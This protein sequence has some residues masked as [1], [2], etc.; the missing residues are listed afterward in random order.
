MKVCVRCNTPLKQGETFCSK[1]GGNQ[2][3]DVQPQQNQGH[4]QINKQPQQQAPNM[5]NQN[6]QMQGQYNPN[7]QGQYNPNMQ[8]Q[9][10]Y[11]QP[12]RGPAPVR[13]GMNQVQQPV[14]PAPKKKLFKSKAEKQAEM[15]AEMARMKQ[16]QAQR[17]QGQQYGQPQ[18]QYGQP[19]Q[20]Y[21]QP[22][23]QYGQPQ[24]QYGQQSNN[25]FSELPNTEMTVKDWIITLLYL[26]IPIWN[27]IYIVKNMN[28]P[29][30]G[31]YK[32]NF[33][34]A[35]GIYFLIS[36]GVRFP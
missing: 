23:Q 35:Y 12:N 7:M 5:Y 2:F 1:C 32:R 9:G 19:Q 4:V 25:S 18:Q 3:R 28:N 30:M 21:G 10:Q 27:I 17:Q 14:E 20:Q 22:Q 33:L 8:M 6:M 15:Q 16:M 11:N 26:L 36:F 31:E 13:P 34:K 24:Q 29:V